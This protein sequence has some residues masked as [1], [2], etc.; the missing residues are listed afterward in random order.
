[1]ETI[2][3]SVNGQEYEIRSFVDN[4]LLTIAVFHGSQKIWSCDV[5]TS[6]PSPSTDELIKIAKDDLDRGATEGKLI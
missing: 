5:D 1:M 4:N 6:P 2:K 3:H